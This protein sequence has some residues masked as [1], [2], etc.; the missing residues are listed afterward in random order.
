[1]LQSVE[2]IYHDGKIELVEPA[3]EGAEGRVIVTFLSP[4][5]VDLRKRGITP[6]QAAD[7]R[8]RLSTFAEDWNDPAMDSYDA[9]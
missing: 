5:A 6:E 3:P 2:G 4:G 8:G 9:L 7:L 1:M